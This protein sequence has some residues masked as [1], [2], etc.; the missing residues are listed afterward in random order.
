MKR[1][2][3]TKR[4]KVKRGRLRL[5]MNLIGTVLLVVVILLCIP[6][7]VPRIFGYQVY[8][9][10]S[11][12]MEPAIPTGSLVYAKSVEPADVETDDVIVFYGSA[13][14]GAIITHR[15]VENHKVSGE[16][17]TKGDAN[18]ENDPLPVDY[19]YLLGEVSLSVP[20]LGEILAMLVTV[21]GKIAVVCMIGAAV[22]F[23]IIGSR[24]Q[25]SES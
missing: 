12:S 5:L 3:R 14:T 22:I 25:S 7:T 19:D 10:I 13:D 6:V 20:Y 8:N 4:R 16:F 21:H 9:V 23:F 11:G 15:V 18:E 24:L 17:I 1:E 2:K